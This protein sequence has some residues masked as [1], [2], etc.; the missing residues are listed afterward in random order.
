MSRQAWKDLQFIKKIVIKPENPENPMWV[1]FKD[2]SDYADV[3]ELSASSRML[4]SRDRS[5]KLRANA[6]YEIQTDYPEDFKKLVVATGDVQEAYRAYQQL[7]KKTPD[8]W[9]DY[10][11]ENVW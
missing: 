10:V 1:E 2:E 9:A 11:E 6:M 3:F 8:N 7:Q 5:I 4:I